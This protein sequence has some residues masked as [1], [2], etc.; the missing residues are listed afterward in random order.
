M[1]RGWVYA[2]VAD[3]WLQCKRLHNMSAPNMTVVGSSLGISAVIRRGNIP[4]KMALA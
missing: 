4:V 2:D 1:S 3:G